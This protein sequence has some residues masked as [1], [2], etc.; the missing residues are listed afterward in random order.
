MAVKGAKA[1]TD[2]IKTSANHLPSIVR[3]YHLPSIV[4]RYHL[5]SIVCRYDYDELVSLIYHIK[6]KTKKVEKNEN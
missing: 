1:T 3:R 6:P 4:R 2:E 5:P